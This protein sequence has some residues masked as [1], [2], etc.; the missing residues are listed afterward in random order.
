MKWFCWI[1]LAGAV[2]LCGLAA[3]LLVAIDMRAAIALSGPSL[4]ADCS[5][6]IVADSPGDP[7]PRRL[8]EVGCNPAD[9][10]L[11]DDE[12]KAFG[13]I[14]S[15]PDSQSRSGR[16]LRGQPIRWDSQIKPVVRRLQGLPIRC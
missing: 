2:G 12:A 8:P 10:G 13:G 4:R 1:I 7:D 5:G 16:F 15:T 3:G 9:M 11:E 6:K 14:G